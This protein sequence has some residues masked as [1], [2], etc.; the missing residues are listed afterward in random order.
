MPLRSQP[1]VLL[2]EDHHHLEQEIR[3]DTARANG[4]FAVDS[5]A[6]VMDVKDNS[7]LDMLEIIL[8]SDSNNSQPPVNTPGD[9]TST[10]K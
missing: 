4:I 8:L 2:Y 6:L 5:Y 7:Q 3:P 9:G 1:A 10:S